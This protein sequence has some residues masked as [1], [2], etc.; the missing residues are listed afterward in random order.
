MDPDGLSR[1]LAPMPTITNLT[2]VE[3]LQRHARSRQDSILDVYNLLLALFVFVSPWLFAYASRSAR[4]DFWACGGL[5]AIVS[6]AAVVAFSDWE[7]WLNLLL[8]L[9]LV[10]APWLLGF[11]H[12][13]AMHMSVG[14]GLVIA[15]L[16]GLELWLDHYRDAS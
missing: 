4:I 3:P 6:T 15:Y 12:S 13:K 9:W 14:V 1:W 11:A 16:A 2:R 8:G 5:I 10:A 7:E